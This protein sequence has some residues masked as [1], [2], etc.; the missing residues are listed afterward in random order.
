MIL[1]TMAYKNPELT[2]LTVR[3]LRARRR[4]LAKGL[5]V[6]G[7]PPAHRTALSPPGS[8]VGG[9]P[10]GSEKKGVVGRGENMP[11]VPLGAISGAFYVRQSRMALVGGTTKPPA[12]QY[13]LAGEAA[14]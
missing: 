14:R 8:R 11:T 4:R 9:G 5:P 13:G 3:Q 6:Q 1:C 12:R 2:E 10:A 7:R